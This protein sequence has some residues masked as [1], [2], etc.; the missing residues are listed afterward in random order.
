MDKLQDIKVIPWDIEEWQIR[1]IEMEHL[2]ALLIP[3]KDIDVWKNMYELVLLALREDFYL[4][5]GGH[6]ESGSLY[7][8]HGTSLV[9]NSWT[10]KYLDRG[11]DKDWE[12]ARK[13]HLCHVR[14]WF[15]PFFPMTNR[16]IDVFDINQDEDSDNL[17]LKVLQNLGLTFY[18]PW[19]ENNIEKIRSYVKD[20]GD[21]IYVRGHILS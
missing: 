18:K 19:L 3:K 10:G 2:R 17:S 7:Y 14:Y 12:P 6:G 16:L 11:N 9:K 5:D 20:K 21:L 1:S 15:G 4:E 8:R 13:M